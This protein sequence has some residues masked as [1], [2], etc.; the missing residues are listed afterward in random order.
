MFEGKVAEI[1]N[2][3]LGAFV[4]G[5]DAKALNIGVWSGQIVLENLQVR[6]VGKHARTAGYITPALTSLEC[7][8]A[9]A[10]ARGAE[11]AEPADNRDGESSRRC[12]T[13]ADTRAQ[14][15]SSALLSEHCQGADCRAASAVLHRRVCWASS[16]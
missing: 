7:R 6:L 11:C 2:K 1:L 9:A 16:R 13:Q 12:G 3:Q 10:Q 14:L 8:L 15:G 5:L 4:E